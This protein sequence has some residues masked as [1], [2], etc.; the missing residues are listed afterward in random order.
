MTIK[1]II[2][3]FLLNTL[4]GLLLFAYLYY[5]HL[6]IFPTWVDDWLSFIYVAIGANFIGYIISILNIGLNK[7][8]FWKTKIG[9]RF[10]LGLAV[11]YTSILLLIYFCLYCF[12]NI[13][14]ISNS[15]GYVFNEYSE[16][17]ARVYILS[18]VLVILLVVSDFLIYSYKYY[19]QGQLKTARLSREQKELQLEALKTQ[20]SPHYLFNSL[21]TVSSLIYKDQKQSEEYIRKLASTYKYILESDEKPLIK[22]KKEINFIKD[23]CYL[24]K[25]R[26]GDS[27]SFYIDVF[28]NCENLLIPP[29]SVQILVENAVKHNVFDS[30]SPLH[31]DIVTNNNS[32]FVRNKILKSPK[33]RESFKIGLSN[34][35]KRYEVFTDTNIKIT[36]TDFFQVELPLLKSEFN[37]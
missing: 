16:I 12:V 31:V 4:I 10:I 21:N 28:K 6:G 15:L 17:V 26:F 11:N 8:P 18:M 30:E 3:I 25:I 1:K 27:F 20:L 24:L 14:G 5:S 29:I 13:S 22:L 9:L 7:I 23:Y 33:E 32:V 35:K 19:S 34:I 37:G 36:K 2:S